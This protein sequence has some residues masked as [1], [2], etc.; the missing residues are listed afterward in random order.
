[1]PPRFYCPDLFSPGTVTL[2]EA[3]S[4]HLAHVL[5]LTTGAIVEL[6]NGQGLVGQA[7]VE[8]VRK[9]DVV[10]TVSAM[11]QEPVS[12]PELILATAIPKGDRFDWLVEKAVELG[13]T[14]LIP[15]QT[16]RSTVD[17]RGS[18]L[19]RLRQTIVSACKQCRRS[20]VMILDSVTPWRDLLVQRT[21]GPLL[22]AHPGGTSLSWLESAAKEQAWVT[23]VGPE[24]GFTDEEISAGLQK[25]GRLI[26]LGEHLLRIETAGIALATWG[27]WQRQ[28]FGTVKTGP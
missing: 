4:H 26:G 15:L 16:A 24:G 18:K 14:R 25:G 21:P 3:E 17:P 22:I 28:T 5:R 13:V 2:T 9:R 11:H 8:A 1:M 20:R 12:L 6:F 27:L 7:V 19:D 23:C 10:C